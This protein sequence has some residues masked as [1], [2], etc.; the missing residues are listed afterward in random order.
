MV[1]K[2]L[3]CS[4]FVTRTVIFLLVQNWFTHPNDWWTARANT[5]KL[6]HDYA[7]LS[8]SCHKAFVV[9]DSYLKYYI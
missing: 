1:L 9:A 2:T 6:G 4:L 7:Y 8:I 3:C 5:S